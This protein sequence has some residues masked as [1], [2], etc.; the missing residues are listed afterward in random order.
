MESPSPPPERPHRGHAQVL[1]YDRA[2]GNA[3]EPKRECEAHRGGRERMQDIFNW[4]ELCARDPRA[5]RECSGGCHEYTER[6]V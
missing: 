6:Y 2:A 5:V 4:I 3:P 1:P